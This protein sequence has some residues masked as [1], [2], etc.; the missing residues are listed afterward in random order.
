MA[1]GA[2]QLDTFDYKPSLQKYA[3]QRLPKVPGLSG[4]IEGF[5]NSP[6]RA[7][8]SPF[9][10]KKRGQS[11]HWMSTLLPRLG[12]C[13]DDLAFIHGIKVENN[14]HGPATMSVNTGSQFQGNPSVGSW[15]TFGLGTRTR[16]SPAMW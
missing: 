7:I 3:G 12:E 1:G 6:H 8:P 4:E 15:V 16:I 13:V 2:S 14:N 9:E 11:G 10:F 5:L